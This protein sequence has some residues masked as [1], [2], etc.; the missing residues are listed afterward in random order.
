MSFLVIN[1]KGDT[2]MRRA[3]KKVPAKKTSRLYLMEFKFS[4][5]F[6]AIK[7]GKASGKS[8]EMRLMNIVLEYFKLYRETPYIKILRDVPCTHVFKRETLFHN[9]HKAKRFYPSQAFTGSTELFSIS[10]EDA[11]LTF[12]RIIGEAIKRD[13]VKECA[14]CKVAKSTIC[15]HTDNSKKKDGLASRC[16][17][18][19]KQGQRSIK[20]LYKRIHSN[21]VAHSKTRGHPRPAYTSKEL[22]AWLD[23]Q[24]LYKT[25]YTTYKNSSYDKKLV[26]SV[27]RIDPALPYVVG[28]IQLMSFSENMQKNLKDQLLEKGEPI[29]VF[30]VYTGVLLYSCSSVS[31]ACEVT[32]CSPKR[33]YAEFIGAI[34]HTGRL[35]RVYNYCFVYT[36][37]LEYFVLPGDTSLKREFQYSGAK[38]LKELQVQYIEALKECQEK[39]EKVVTVDADAIE[40]GEL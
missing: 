15:F 16:K 9:I 26:P 31:N 28:N 35:S 2:R 17:V 33:V 25:L 18:C 12:D 13:E 27:D 34:G 21:Q 7:C 39:P 24:P 20:N 22:G 10:K 40:P 11:L 3:S 1:G 32:G 14:S 36:E 19:I 8:S 37:C 30:D 5:G 6:T 23:A 38:E 4:D 29:T